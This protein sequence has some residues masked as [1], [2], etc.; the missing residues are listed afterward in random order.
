VLVQRTHGPVERRR[1]LNP[2]SV[3]QVKARFDAM[4][5]PYSQMKASRYFT[6]DEVLNYMMAKASAATRLI[7]L[8][9]LYAEGKIAEAQ[10]TVAE[11]GEYVDTMKTMHQRKIGLRGSDGYDDFTTSLSRL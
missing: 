10:A 5:L 6:P 8:P 3:E 11:I 9:K 7:R 1:T 2:K 4:A